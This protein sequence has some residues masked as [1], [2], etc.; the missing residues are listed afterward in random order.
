MKLTILRLAGAGIIS[1]AVGASAHASSITIVNTGPFSH[2]SATISNTW[3]MTRTNMNMV[4]VSSWNRQTATS[5]NAS[6]WFNTFG[7]SAMSGDA[8]NWNS[9]ST[10]VSITN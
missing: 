9:S 6:V 1:L 4:N 7:G 10:W 2:N 8:S 3:T 5:G